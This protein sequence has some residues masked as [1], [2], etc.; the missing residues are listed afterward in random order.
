MDNA[1]NASK[2]IYGVLTIYDE[3]GVCNES[4]SPMRYNIGQNFSKLGS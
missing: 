1:H 3:L 2:Y 4:I